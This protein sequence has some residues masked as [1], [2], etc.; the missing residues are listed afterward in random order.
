[1]I[2]DKAAQSD[3]RL[4]AA[5]DKRSMAEIFLDVLE[6]HERRGAG[7]ARGKITKGVVGYV[8]SALT[9]VGSA[10]YSYANTLVTHDEM[11]Q[12]VSP[13]TTKLESAEVV[14]TEQGTKLDHIAQSI[15]RVRTRTAHEDEI[16]EA[17]KLVDEYQQDFD[18][19][20]QT[21]VDGNRKGEAPQRSDGFIA[22][23]VNLR[24]L[25]ERRQRGE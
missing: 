2:R 21:W 5:L 17:Q 11:T 15:A 25:K 13:I 8:L 14:L 19:M 12:T 24:T 4:T 6:S 22:A 20:M 23:K 10:A 18:S 16:Q 9:V 1:M 7:G 3:P